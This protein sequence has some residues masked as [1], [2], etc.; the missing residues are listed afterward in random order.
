MNIVGRRGRLS[1]RRTL[2][3]EEIADVYNFNASGT[4]ERLDVT[5]MGT[6]NKKYI[7][8]LKEATMTFDAYLNDEDI[9]QT[10]LVEGASFQ[11]EFQFDRERP[12]GHGLDNPSDDL[13]GTMFIDSVD[14]S[15]SA[16]DPATISV[17]G[18]GNFT[19]NINN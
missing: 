6:D 2:S 17:T 1:I 13:T 11:V 5:P 14:R 19:Y 7:N 8:G 18:T 15:V 16:N 3:F 12:T 10:A 9:T 4:A